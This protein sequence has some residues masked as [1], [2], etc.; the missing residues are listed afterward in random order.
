MNHFYLGQFLPKEESW[1]EVIVGG[2]CALGLAV[3]LCLIIYL[4]A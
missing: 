4:C 3:L 2:V 1:G